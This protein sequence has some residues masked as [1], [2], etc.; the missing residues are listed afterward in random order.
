MHNVANQIVQRC[1][2]GE[3]AMPTIVR[4]HEQAPHEE[5]SYQPA[6]AGGGPE[7][8]GAQAH[9]LDG[10]ESIDAGCYACTITGEVVSAWVRTK[11]THAMQS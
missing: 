2:L 3:R 4:D 11:T 7:G 9:F 6:G 10:E 5:S 8:W 1:I